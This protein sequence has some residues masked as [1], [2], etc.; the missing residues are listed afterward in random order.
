MINIPE[1]QQ[2]RALD[3]KEMMDSRWSRSHWY[4]TKVV[5]DAMSNILKLRLNTDFEKNP[6][7][8][9]ITIS[10][11]AVSTSLTVGLS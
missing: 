8:I 3:M 2:F 5:G 7:L 11:S 10:T 4:H 6:D 1:L 9:C